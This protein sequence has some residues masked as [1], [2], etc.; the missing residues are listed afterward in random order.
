VA[1]ENLV[2]ADVPLWFFAVKAPA[3]QFALRGTS[4]DLEE[5]GLTV[6]DLRNAGATVVMDE[7][8]SG[9][10]RLLAWTE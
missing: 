3:A 8:R 10:E 2:E 4:F 9:G 5:I 6:D 7:T 1:T